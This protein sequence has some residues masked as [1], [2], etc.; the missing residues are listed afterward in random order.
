VL[1]EQEK[2]FIRENCSGVLSTFRRNGAV[3]LSIVSVGI[4]KGGVA[5]S[6]VLGRSKVFNLNRNPCCSLLISVKDW[7]SYIV[8][9]GQANILSSVNTSPNELK[10]SLRK[11]YREILG[12]HPNWDEYDRAMIK[13]E[14]VVVVVQPLHVYG[15]LR[16]YPAL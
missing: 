15:T 6:T 7:S 14:R 4:F 10:E 1:R 3:Q 8:L 11:V 9:E 12:E 13:D 2:T 16:R 5:F